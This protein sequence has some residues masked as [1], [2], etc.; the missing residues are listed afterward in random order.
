MRTIDETPFFAPFC[1]K[2]DR[3]Y[4]DML[5]TYIRKQLKQEGVSVSQGLI[6]SVSVLGA[7]GAVGEEVMA[8]GSFDSTA[9]T[10]LRSSS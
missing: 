8:F 9:R 4:Q 5:G 10:T 1:C 3:F 7:A 2:S 6:S